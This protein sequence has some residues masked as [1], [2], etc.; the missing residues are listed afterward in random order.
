MAGRY[1]GGGHT[2]GG[3]TVPNKRNRNKDFSPAASIRRLEA[4]REK[5]AETLQCA[6]ENADTSLVLLCE[7]NMAT[8]NR[9]IQFYQRMIQA[10]VAV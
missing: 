3:Q 2:R 1:Y 7:R 4:D 6:L 5:W 8:V 10:E 9:S